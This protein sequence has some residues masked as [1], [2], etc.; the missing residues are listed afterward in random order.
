MNEP[1]YKWYRRFFHVLAAVVTVILLVLAVTAE[2][3]SRPE[4][5]GSHHYIRPYYESWTRSTHSEVECG[6]C[7]YPPGMKGYLVRKWKAVSEV[8]LFVT[9]TYEGEPHAEVKDEGCLRSGC[10]STDNVPGLVEY[11]T[12]TFSHRK[13]LPCGQHHLMGEFSDIDE[14]PEGMAASGNQPPEGHEQFLE[15]LPRGRVLRCASCHSQIVQGDTDEHMTVTESTCFLCHFKDT[16][17][18][19]PIAGCPSC[20]EPPDDMVLINGMEFSHRQYLDEDVDCM[21]CHSGVVEGD[22]AVPQ[23]RC[24]TC[25]DRVERLQEYENHTVIHQVHVTDHTI[26]C[27]NCHLEIRH[28]KR[29]MTQTLELDCRGCHIETHAETQALYVGLGDGVSSLPDPMFLARVSCIGCHTTHENNTMMASADTCADCHGETYGHMEEQ[30]Q[31]GAM[32]LVGEIGGRRAQ[33]AREIEMVKGNGVSPDDIATAEALLASADKNISTITLG[34]PVHNVKFSE[35]L[36]MTANAQLAM[37]LGAL[38]GDEGIADIAPIGRPN[39]PEGGRC[40]GCH[41]GIETVTVAAFGQAFD[42]GP[43]VIDEQLS[44]EKCHSS[45]PQEDEGHGATTV[46]SQECATC[47]HEQAK[48]NDCRTCHTDLRTRSVS[49]SKPFDHGDHAQDYVADCAECHA[50]DTERAFIGECVSCHHTAPVNVEGKC[51]KCHAAQY[52]VFDGTVV[53]PSS[54]SI[55]AEA[56]VQCAECHATHETPVAT[57][58]CAECHDEARYADMRRAWQDGTRRK[59]AAV[60]EARTSGQVSRGLIAEMERHIRLIQ[61]DGSQGFHNPE[62]VD[63]LLSRDLERAGIAPE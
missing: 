15:K 5:C 30:W 6:K 34:N 16:P 39:E 61:R 3:T 14:M 58:E 21:Q 48:D 22:G 11:K 37:A 35:R 38:R 32:R 46:T 17:S 4:F 57:A 49:Y 60:A 50:G 44:C 9:N 54:P 62:L 20:H 56:D 41:F 63:T 19:Q 23:E 26:D 18:G 13:H 10:H 29:D 27:L 25:H 7:H 2:I 42:H 53:S 33:V 43:H 55:H 8:A 52:A 51:A 47:H 12:L 40:L 36:V 59:L 28:G 1:Q 45:S 31:T 24:Y